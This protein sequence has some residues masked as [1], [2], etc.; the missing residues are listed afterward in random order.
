MAAVKRQAVDWCSANLPEGTWESRSV[1]DEP[2][3]DI[4]GWFHVSHFS[5]RNES[6]MVMFCIVFPEL[7]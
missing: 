4:A 3:E 5:F 1:F 6:D 7:K 2:K